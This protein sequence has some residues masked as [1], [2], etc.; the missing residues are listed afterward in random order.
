MT[1]AKPSP[2]DGAPLDL[3]AMA[4]RTLLEANMPL[5]ERYIHLLVDNAERIEAATLERAAKLLEREA[6]GYRRDDR[7]FCAVHHE[8]A[9]EALDD[10]ASAIRALKRGGR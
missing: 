6:T 1:S 3:R 9:I 7:G 10:A 2:A 8:G 4:V 5:H